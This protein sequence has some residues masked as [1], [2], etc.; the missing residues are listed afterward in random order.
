MEKLTPIT[1]TNSETGKTYTLEFNRRTC[2]LAEN[3]G[4]SVSKLADEDRLM[5]V[6]PELFYH[7]FL[8]H[9]PTVK[10]AETDRILFDEIGGFTPEL[11]TRLVELFAQPYNSLVKQ[12]GEGDGKN[13]KWS[14][15]L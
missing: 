1:L 14:V 12:E 3:A 10:K 4:I 9:H 5:S 2:A 15:T 11:M 7:A 8:M 13:A 6:Y